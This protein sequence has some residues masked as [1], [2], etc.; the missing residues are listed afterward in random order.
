[1]VIWHQSKAKINR[2]FGSGPPET[3][4]TH[5]PTC[6]FP[7]EI[8]E[9]IVA[10]SDDLD[11]LKA[12]SLA[13]RSWYIAALPHIH[14]T[15]IL[16][17]GRSDKRHDKLKPLSKLHK[18]GL[19]PL[20]KQIT[21]HQ[22]RDSSWFTP[23][24]FSRRD[25]HCLSPFTN[26]RTLRLDS[27]DVSRFTP[28][29]E[30]HFKHFSPTLRS[31]MLPNPCCTPRQLSYFLSFFSNLD[32]ICI[33]GESKHR[34]HT[35]S[36]AELVPFSTQGLQ[37]QLMLYNCRWIKTWTQLITSC[38]GLRFRCMHLYKV[39]TCAPI[40]FEACAETLETLRI[41][42]RDGSVGK[43]FNVGLSMD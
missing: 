36:D 5:E 35:T 20:V 7:Q 33:I 22:Q 30:H 23:E 27:L 18:L 12:C 31:I 1:M 28:D 15:L 6:R 43:L 17:E 25:L 42:P 38:G 19:A 16:K 39:G 9:M 26:V 34:P 10:Q 41:Y 14:H 13:C 37:G 4:T 3:R 40:L 32:D 11:T 29:M 24:A 2:L 8:V 21:V